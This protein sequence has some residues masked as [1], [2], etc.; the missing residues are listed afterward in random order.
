MR[1]LVNI[2]KSAFRTG[3]YVGYSYHGVWRITKFSGGWYGH[4]KGLSV[5]ADTLAQISKLITQ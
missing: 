3:E 2:E 1:N 5:S 4:C